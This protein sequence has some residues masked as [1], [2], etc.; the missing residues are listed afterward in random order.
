[1]LF[2]N[3]FV[4]LENNVPGSTEWW[5][6]VKDGIKGAGNEVSWEDCLGDHTWEPN[7][8]KE[9]H[10]LEA[11]DTS[12]NQSADYQ[13]YIAKDWEVKHSAKKDK[14]CWLERQAE[15]TEHA[16]MNNDM[17]TFY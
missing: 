15:L 11:F 13:M 5:K 4:T 1:M 2:Q 7:Q 10:A 3:R 8:R 12:T 16:T 14:Q 6:A 17:W 9:M